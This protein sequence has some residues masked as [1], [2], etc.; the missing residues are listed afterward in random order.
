MGLI[1]LGALSISVSSAQLHKLIP[2][3]FQLQEN[4][5]LAFPKQFH[6]ETGTK[7]SL[8]ITNLIRGD[9]LNYK[10]HDKVALSLGIHQFTLNLFWLEISFFHRLNDGSLRDKNFAAL[11]VVNVQINHTFLFIWLNIFIYSPECY[12]TFLGYIF[13]NMTAVV[14]LDSLTLLV[15]LP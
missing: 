3:C 12:S 2:R 6:V 5:T 15:I 1:R 4:V 10:D 8:K 13:G 7:F 11:H 14:L 9:V